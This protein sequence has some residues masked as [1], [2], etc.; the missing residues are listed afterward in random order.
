MHIL[1][2]HSHSYPCQLHRCSSGRTSAEGGPATPAAYT[3]TDGHRTTDWPV[4]SLVSCS[5][6]SLFFVVAQCREKSD[7]YKNRLT[8]SSVRVRGRA[9]TKT[10]RTTAKG[11]CHDRRH[12][13]HSSSV[14]GLKAAMPMCPLQKRQKAV[15]SDA[16]SWPAAE[17]ADT[18]QSVKQ[19]VRHLII[20][21]IVF[22]CSYFS[23]WWSWGSGGWVCRGGCQGSSGPSGFC[24]HC[25]T[26]LTDELWICRR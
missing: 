16:A 26:V 5:T 20:T 25:T 23:G 4:A 1:T 14:D 15:A 19:D 10:N 24:Q 6:P 11:R 18:L 3:R 13:G 2:T 17:P 21:N 22:T 8:R 9:K 12:Q 7:Y